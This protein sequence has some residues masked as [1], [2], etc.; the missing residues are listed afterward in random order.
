MS[1]DRW[2]VCPKCRVQKEKTLEQKRQEAKDSYGKIE[3][4]R[5]LLLVKELEKLE[6]DQN[7]PNNAPRTLRED[8]EL[9][10]N[11]DGEFNVN[12]SCGCVECGFRYDYHI[13]QQLKLE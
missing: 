7:N 3:A 4:G 6:S 1:A 5:Y 12:Y 8:W 11:A 9:G 2:C 10:T 13:N